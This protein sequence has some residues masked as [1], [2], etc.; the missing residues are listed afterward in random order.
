MTIPM[1]LLYKNQ[2]TLQAYN[3]LL[4]KIDKCQFNEIEALREEILKFL[5]DV[6]FI[7]G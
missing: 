7:Q 4:S 5:E 3:E 2:N 6:Y 1:Y